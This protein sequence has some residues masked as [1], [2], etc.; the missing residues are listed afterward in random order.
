MAPKAP[1][2]RK[3]HTIDGLGPS[4]M[5]ND[6][7]IGSGMAFLVGE[8]EKRDPR[9]LEPLSSV[10]WM[11]DIVSKTG[12]GWVDFTSNQFIDYA[13]TGG[14]E[15][16]IIGGETND[17]PVMQANTTKDIYKVFNFANIL[18]VPFIDQQKLQNI[19]RSLDDIL[20]KGIRLNYNKSIDN[21][22]YTGVPSAGVYGLVNSPDITA[23]AVAAGES[24][25]TKWNKKTPDEILADINAIITD[26]WAASEY[27]LTGMANHILIPPQQYAFLVGTKVS[28]AGNISIL[29]FLLDNNIGKNQGIDLTIAPSRWCSEAGTGGTD[30]MVAYVN[31]E[32]R[33]NFD[34]TV[35]LSRVMTQ[36]QVTEMAYLT[37]YAAQIGQVKFLY[38][39]CARYGDGI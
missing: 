33:V 10:T 39:Q 15:D 11:R 5:M 35:P 7:A 9:L 34:L 12:G 31:D 21:I 13:T 25:Q 14:N 37:A 4:M 6:A 27:D 8:L 32:D 36:S 3:V 1:L 28:E 18:K 20:D 22:V 17:I 26:T 2:A 38:T 29:Q 16:G 24:G 23:S 19:G 30:R